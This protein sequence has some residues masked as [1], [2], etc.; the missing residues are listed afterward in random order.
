MKFP[1]I[2]DNGFWSPKIIKGKCSLCG[3]KRIDSSLFYYIMGG[4]LYGKKNNC[5]MNK[6][7]F[8]FLTIGIHNHKGKHLDIVESSWDGQFDLYFC[9]KKCLKKFFNDIVD[10]LEHA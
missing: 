7:M 6:K 9:S 1:V 10:R 5:G 3:V 8:G 2:K 4:A